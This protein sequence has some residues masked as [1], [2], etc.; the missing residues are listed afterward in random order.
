MAD[1]SKECVPHSDAEML[2]NAVE[3]RHKV[4]AEEVRALV[5]AG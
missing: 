5:E 1:L 4:V 3:R 2:A